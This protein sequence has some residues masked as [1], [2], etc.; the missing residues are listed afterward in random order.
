MEKKEIVIIGAGRYSKTLI[1][2]LKILPKVSLIVIDKDV[3]KLESISG[4]K[5]I[6]VGDATN[7]DFIKGIGIENADYYIIGVGSDFQS[8]LLIAT[9]IK[10]NFSGPVIAKSVN[11]QHEIILHKIGVE[12]VITPEVTAAKRTFAKIINPF[13][14]KGLEQYSMLEV[15]EDVSIVRVPVKQDWIDKAVKDIE[16]IK[17]I[18]ISLIY[19]KGTK[20]TIV[21]GATTFE[22][23]DVI[24]VVGENKSLIKFLEEFENTEEF[25]V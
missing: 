8:S 10:Q 7:E 24:A 25:T 2:R 23:K 17:G 19:R 4:V 6:I 13:V 22:K 18:A 9:N 5:N 14:R 11:E 15:S 21:T 16:L 3:K 20:A 1:E 12:D